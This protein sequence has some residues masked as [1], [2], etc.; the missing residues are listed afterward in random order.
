M[1][2]LA[3]SGSTKTDWACVD[4]QQTFHFQT[5]GLNPYFVTE[6]Q[7]CD[8]ISRNFLQ[9]TMHNAQFAMDNAYMAVS[10]IYFYGSGCGRAESKQVIENALRKLFSRAEIIVD[11]DLKGAA[12]ACYGNGKGIVAILGTGMNIGF[13]DGKTLQTPMPSLGYIFGDAGSGAVLGRKLI[14]AVFEKQ[15]SEVLIEKF[16]NTYHVSLPE[17]LDRVYKQPRPNAYLAGFAPFY[18]ENVKNQEIQTI[19]HESYREFAE[20]YAKPIADKYG[21]GEISFVGSIANVFSEILA[22]ELTAFGLKIHA[23]I[24]APIKSFEIFYKNI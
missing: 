24:T 6:E 2:L 15:L 11:S 3:D 9:C 16:Q 23:I 8:E 18:A 19:L 17:M 7:I 21:V 1:I 22:E 14:K 5:I 4:A 10:K 12:I 20:V 13:W